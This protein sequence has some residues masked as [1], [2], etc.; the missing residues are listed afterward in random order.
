MVVYKDFLKKEDF[1]TLKSTMMDNRF[2]WHLTDIIGKRKSSYTKENYKNC[3]FTHNFY[4]LYGHHI[5]PF[6]YLLDPFISKL[7]PKAIV[8]IKANLLPRTDTKIV[9]GMHTDTDF[10][11]TTAVFYVNT[12]N[13]ETVFENGKRFKSEENTLITF[14]SQLQHSGT[15]NTCENANRIV[16][17]LNYL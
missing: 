10:E 8:R 17:N 15:T 13:G 12:N 4:S 9:H 16:L 6:F 14:S 7:K 2:D 11:S 1:E 5:S 3:Q